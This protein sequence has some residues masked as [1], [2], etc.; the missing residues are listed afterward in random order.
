[1]TLLAQLTDLHIVD[2]VQVAVEGRELYV[3]NNRRLELAVDRVVAE[4]VSPDAVI[5]TGDLTDLGTP[6]EMAVLSERLAP[7]TMPV[8]AVPGNHDRRDTFRDTFDLPWAS[9][10]NLSWV[11]DVGPVRIIGLDTVVADR[12]RVH[13]LDDMQHH[14]EFDDERADWLD[15]A[16][17]EAPDR[18]T[19]IAMH[20]PPFPTGI[21]WMDAMGLRGADRF[22]DVIADRPHLTRIVAGHIHRTITATISG[23]TASTSVATVHQVELDLAPGAPVQIVCDPP[24][25]TLHRFDRQGRWISH[26]R[27]F[28]TGSP[29]INPTWAH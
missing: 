20:H 3:D 29:V 25:Y 5:L 18:P 9:E 15:R 27:H 8:L 23:V 22:A 21:G 7:L 10:S 13:S 2:P 19:M 17:G 24:G 16:L 28:D 14:G 12:D 4:T 11:V 26:V 1:M 6:T